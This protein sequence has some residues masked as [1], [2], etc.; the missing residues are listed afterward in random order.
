M[1][2]YLSKLG[3]L[4]QIR[5]VLMTEEIIG[6]DE[7]YKFIAK[8]L[9]IRFFRR[10]GYDGQ[11]I[12]FLNVEQI[13]VGS[14]QKFMDIIG[15]VDG[16]GKG[17]IE[18]QSAPVY[19]PKMLDMYKYRIYS[20]A[21]EFTDFKTIVFAT[22]PPTRGIEELEIDGDI[23]FHPD[24]FYTKNLNATEIIKTVKG[25]NH[26]NE[27]LSDTEAI[28]LILAPD[29]KHDYDIKDL[30]EITSGLLVNAVIPDRE[31]HLN[32]MACQRKMLQRFFK[33][34]ERKEIEKMINFKAEDYGIEPNVT[35]I[36][37]EINLAYLDGEREGFDKGKIDTA[38]NLIELGSDDEF[39]VN[40]T[41]LDLEDV[42]KLK[43]ELNS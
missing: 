31:F 37:E 5:C 2:K 21:E 30:M 4:N 23:T 34:D 36:E 43:E 33:K 14:D 18:L 38:K 9:D 8:K 29:T 41:G 24:F 15:V 13:P 17:N 25:K 32:L 35:G 39:I 19:D 40:A 6:E 10:L 42:K 7:T 16:G 26:N 3:N 12:V 27:P 22:Y 11:E 28:D 1:S 20:Q